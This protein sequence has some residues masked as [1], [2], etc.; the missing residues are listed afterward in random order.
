MYLEDGVML[1]IGS[2]W[3]R[4]FVKS[5]LSLLYVMWETSVFVRQLLALQKN[6]AVGWVTKESS[7]N[8]RQE[9]NFLSSSKHPD[10]L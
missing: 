2:I 6:N 4:A 8:F 9:R 5:E 3:L 1:L 10:N 7:I